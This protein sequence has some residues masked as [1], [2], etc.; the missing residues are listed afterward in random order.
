MYKSEKSVINRYERKFIF[1]G[2]NKS[3]IENI[4][5]LNVG[6]FKEI[7]EERFINN[8]Y[9]DDY[10]FSSF[11]DNVNGTGSRSKYRIRWY[12][13]FVIKNKQAYFEV[14]KKEVR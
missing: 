10:L 3:D 13:K 9:F 2:A 5:K 14:K 6:G 8:I 11:N 12:G 7:H 1:N 4:I